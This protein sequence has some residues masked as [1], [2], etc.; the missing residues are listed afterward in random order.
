MQNAQNNSKY[1]TVENLVA[2]Y[3]KYV[4]EHCP[5]QYDVTEWIDKEGKAHLDESYTPWIS[6]TV[7][8]IHSFFTGLPV[9]PFGR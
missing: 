4:D 5:K 8:L 2:K 3:R 1:I 6:G 9:S 7:P